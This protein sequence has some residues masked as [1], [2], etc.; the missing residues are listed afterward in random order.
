MPD[1]NKVPDND[2]SANLDPVDSEVGEHVTYAVVLESIKSDIETP[3][4]FA[5]KFAIISRLPVTKVKHIMRKMPATVW[6]SCKKP[7]AQKL[8]RLIEEAG[9]RGKIVED[10]TI[11]D[12][13]LAAQETQS[14]STPTCQ[15]CGFP[16]KEDDKYCSFCMTPVDAQEKQEQK[17][18]TRKTV[19]RKPPVVPSYRLFFYFIILIAGILISLALR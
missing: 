14:P 11:V 5:L 7:Q 8:L 18:E 19:V 3:E 13:H 4:S 15:R 9:G 10:H 1:E 2:P 12:E 16:L 17:V 6:R